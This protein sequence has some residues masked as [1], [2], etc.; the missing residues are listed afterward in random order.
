MEEIDYT[1]KQEEPKISFRQMCE[2]LAMIFAIHVK[3]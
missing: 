1:P 2:F 3:R